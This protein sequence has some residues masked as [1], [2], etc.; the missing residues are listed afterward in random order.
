MAGEHVPSLARVSLI[1]CIA[2]RPWIHRMAPL[3]MGGGHDLDLCGLV[4]LGA[5]LRRL[6]GIHGG[7]VCDLD[8]PPPGQVRLPNRNGSGFWRDTWSRY[9]DPAAHPV[10][11]ME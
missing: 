9:A 7:A 2:L 4:L 8:L 6:C 1:R 3:A 11:R 10:P 5:R